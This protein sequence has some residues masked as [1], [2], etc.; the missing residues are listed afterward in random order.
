MMNPWSSGWSPIILMMTLLNKTLRIRMRKNLTSAKMSSI[1]VD[2]MAGAVLLLMLRTEK[3]LILNQDVLDL[4]KNI[5][6]TKLFAKFAKKSNHHMSSGNGITETESGI[7]GL[8]TVEDGLT[9]DLQWEVSHQKDGLGIEASG[10]IAA[11][12]INGNPVSGG[13]GKTD[14]GIISENTY[15]FLQKDQIQ[16]RNAENSTKEWSQA[17]TQP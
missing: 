9:G 2:F 12:P 13:D 15:P 1:I 3:S 4:S 8:H 17:S 7:D 14:N 11:M 6:V 5:Q 16:R 10:I